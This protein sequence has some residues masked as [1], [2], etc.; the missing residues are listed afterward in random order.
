MTG[1]Q[2]FE[3]HATCPDGDRGPLRGL[4][5]VE[6]GSTV[7]GPFCARLLADFGASVV[8]LEQPGGD[9]VRSM[10]TQCDG[11]SLYGA[12]I[13]RN[14]QL[15]CIDLRQE[16]GRELARRLCEKADIVV[17]NF[18]P[19]T[20]ERWGLGYEAL[21]ASNPGLILVR[22]SGF[23]QDGP[24]SSRG[25]YGV[26][27]EAVS[28]L[29]GIN[30]DPDRPP[31]RAATSLA[32]YIAGLYAAFGAVMAVVERQRTGRGQVVDSA[33]YEGSFSFMEPHVPAYQKLGVVARRAGPR[34][35]GNTP[36]SIY[37]T[38]DGGYV[39]IAAASD[40]VFRRLC[41]A[42]GKPALAD[43]PRF[44]TGLAR[45]RHAD[46]C[47]A[48]IADWSGGRTM[49]EIEEIL[50][51][52]GVPASRIYSVEDIF[53]DPHYAAREM[54]VSLPDPCLGEVTLTGVVPK[55]SDTPGGVW[56]SGRA[57]GTDTREVL[58]DDLGLSADEISALQREGVVVLADDGPSAEAS[59]Q[60]EASA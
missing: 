15:A 52:V 45:N 16:R 54:L 17:E 8:K 28:G 18:R 32:D 46:A 55:L 21:S 60:R 43:D 12:S 48:E 44:A 57:I 27:G 50:G 33:L 38:R 5:V 59:S 6:L 29:R 56:R 9:A 26:V 30:G 51:A 37:A 1:A 3:G 58:A 13:F 2:R 53:R 14:K 42:I 10:G 4:R 20:L 7:A 49:A 19:G 36:N 31:P 40:S 34:L 22:I 11:H 41:E 35:P 25:G 39:V 23:G 24:Y 47:D